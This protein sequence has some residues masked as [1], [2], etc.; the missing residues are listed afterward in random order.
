VRAG[1]R[2]PPR[3]TLTSPPRPRLAVPS[4]EKLGK[5]KRLM[6]F[7][8]EMR[9]LFARHSSA[10]IHKMFEVWPD[11]VTIYNAET[12][13][14]IMHATKRRG[15]RTHHPLHIATTR[16]ADGLPIHVAHER[17]R[18]RQHS[19]GCLCRRSRPP[20]RNVQMLLAGTRSARFLDTWYAEGNFRAVWSRHKST[21]LLRCRQPCENVSKCYRVRAD[22]KLRTPPARTLDLAQLKSI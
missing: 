16:H 7:S 1:N 9:H 2:V 8:F 18:D 11:F 21:R 20:Q 19:A 13:R 3:R 22:A 4:T 12:S 5:T 17:A 15:P 6:V 14:L 10:G